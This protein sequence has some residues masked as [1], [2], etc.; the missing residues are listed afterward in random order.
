MKRSSALF[1]LA[2][3]DAYSLRA[4]TE[5]ARQQRHPPLETAS[6]EAQLSLPFHSFRSV[7]FIIPAFSNP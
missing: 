3:P 2:R 7:L 5:D 1:F 4:T 6:A